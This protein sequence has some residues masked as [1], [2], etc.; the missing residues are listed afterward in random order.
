MDMLVT[1]LSEGKLCVVDVSQ[2]RGGQA[3][4][5]SGLILRRIFDRN[6][7]EFTAAEPKTI[8]VIA[9]VEEAQAVLNERA[10]A[11]EPYISWVKEGRK[12]DLGAVLVTQQPGSI[13]TEIL[14]QGDN[15]FI[16]HLLSSADLTDVRRA[17]AHF[18]EDLLSVLLNEPIR[19]QGVFW[20]SVAGKPYPLSLRVLS[21]E[22]KYPALDAT[23]IKSPGNTFAAR[24]KERFARVISATETETFHEGPEGDLESGSASETDGA[25]Q[26][27]DALELVER[28]AIDRFRKDDEIIQ[29]LCEVGMPYGG[30]K[31]YF[32]EILPEELEDRDN[33]AYQLV[34]RALNEALGPQGTG[35]HTYKHPTRNT[36]WV[37]QGPSE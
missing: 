4:I 29:K 16:F 37:K 8:P 13:P 1:S 26:T 6:Q 23:S 18:S 11:A 14:S 30:V 19:G 17:N 20:S 24:L 31:Q 34:A 22:K 15:W 35:W 3:M 25:G 33:R 28:N 32:K 21:F 10:T 9:V 27:V 2:M 36:T 12:Y 5:L 7:L